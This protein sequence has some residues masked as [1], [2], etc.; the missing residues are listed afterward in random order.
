M[1]TEDTLFI[2][3]LT[4]SIK[5][6]IKDI[7]LLLP[8][9]F[10]LYHN[11]PNPFNPSTKIAFDIPENTQVKLIVWDIVGKRIRTL[12]NESVSPGNHEVVWDGKNDYGVKVSGGVYLYSIETR[13]FRKTRK[14][15]LLK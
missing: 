9:K 6:Q 4:M 2:N 11:Y 14:M 8:E 10:V 13:A 3:V 5:P 15:L 7:N 1:S 12:V